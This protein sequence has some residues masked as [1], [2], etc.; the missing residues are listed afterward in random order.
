MSDTPTDGR[1][2][3]FHRT[4]LWPG[5]LVTALFVLAFS[6][7]LSVPPTVQYVPLAVSVVLLG[8]PHG[9]VDHFAVSWSRGTAPTLDAVGRVAGLYL[10]LGISYIVMWFISPVASA[11]LFIALT[12]FHW[13]QGDL[14]ALVAV[15]SDDHLRTPGQRALTVLVRGGLPML[16]PLLSFPDWY[17]RVVADL[18]GLFSPGGVSSLAPVFAPR[19]RDGLM[20][21]YGLALVGSLALGYLRAGGRRDLSWALDAGETLLLVAYFTLVPPVLAVG[22]YF[23]FWHSLRH[24]GRLVAVD[25]TAAARLDSGDVAGALGRFARVATPLTVA[26]LVLLAGF[27]LLVPRSPGD[28]TELVAVYLVFIAVVTLPHVVVVSVMDREQRVWR[29]G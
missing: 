26:A 14:Y 11:V 23:C 6:A 7:G 20:V 4:F 10:A 16:V 13:G 2:Q 19:V 29:S 5:W 24:V 17:R 25:D 8:L 15:G 28:F 9:A 18:V 22:V 12:W 27:F 1:W 3:P 21:G